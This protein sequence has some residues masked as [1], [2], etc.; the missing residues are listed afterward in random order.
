MSCEN[1]G[2]LSPEK[3][4]PIL[5][6]HQYGFHHELKIHC[7]DISVFQIETFEKRALNSNAPRTICVSD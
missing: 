2:Y 3:Y 7:S 1:I 4:S 6:N 5:F